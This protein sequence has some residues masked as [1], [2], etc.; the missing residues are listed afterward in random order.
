[1]ILVKAYILLTPETRYKYLIV[2]SIIYFMQMILFLLVSDTV[3]NL[4]HLFNKLALYC[5][6]WGLMVNIEKT[7]IVVF[8]RGGKLKKVEKWFY[9]QSKI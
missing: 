3:Y 6:N 8:K 7:K 4:Q 9:K 1:M 2:M 5:D